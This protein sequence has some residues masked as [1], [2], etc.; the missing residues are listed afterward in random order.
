MKAL[1]VSVN[2]SF[3]PET[4]TM[5]N[6]RDATIHAWRVAQ[7]VAEKC[8]VV[9]MTWHGQIVGAFRLIGVLPNPK[10]PWDSTGRVTR[11]RSSFILGEP[12]PIRPAWH[13][14]KPGLR[15]GVAVV[16]F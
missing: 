14:T 5:D 9:V 8:D 1:Y 3:D 10:F 12:V 13:A 11:M 16:E 7:S 2:R 15:N 4:D 6:L